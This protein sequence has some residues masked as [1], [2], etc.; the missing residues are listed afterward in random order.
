MKLNTFLFTAGL[1][2]AA[3]SANPEPSRCWRVGMPCQK[4][5]RAVD[6]ASEILDEPVDT[7]SVEAKRCFRDGQPCAKA[8]RAEDALRAS[9]KDANINNYTD[10]KSPE[11][12]FCE[13]DKPCPK[14]YK[15]IQARSLAVEEV[16]GQDDPN[17][18]HSYCHT[19]GQ[20]CNKV[21]RAAEALAEALAEPEADPN[22]DPLRCWR[23]GMPCQKVKRDLCF[24]NGQPCHIAKRAID[25]LEIA[26]ND[27]SDYVT[28][29]LPGSDYSEK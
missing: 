29:D 18:D 7:T 12:H 28:E 8:R 17:A 16:E 24:R 14:G 9:L 11:H 19:V 4:L 23:V 27:A 20:Q 3:V 25:Y 15:N 2:I 21:K 10:D 13:N 5:K 6:V 26:A 1:V 22:P